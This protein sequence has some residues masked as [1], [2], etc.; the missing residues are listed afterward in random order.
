[1]SS[2]SNLAQSVHS[3]PKKKTATIWNQLN[4]QKFGTTMC[5]QKGLE[6]TTFSPPLSSSW[7]T[8]ECEMQNLDILLFFG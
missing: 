3:L 7:T 4:E 2:L 6:N 5:F 1:M 8:V